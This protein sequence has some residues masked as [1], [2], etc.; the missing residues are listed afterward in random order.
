MAKG[1]ATQADEQVVLYGSSL[2]AAAFALARRLDPLGSGL[3]ISAIEQGLEDS[4][5]EIR[6][7]SP[8]SVLSSALN[9]EQNLFER[10]ARATW[11]W[12]EPGEGSVP[13][14]G[15]FGKALAGAAYPVA[16][17]LDP[18]QAGIHYEVIKVTLIGEGDE[19]R[20][21]NP[22]QTM[23]SALGQAGDR[24]ERLGRGMSRWL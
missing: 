8:R 14:T 2:A 17:R 24:F 10:S 20:G 21:P 9:G 4:G 15:L 11:R 19:V 23:L 3:H 6:G 7:D 22:G 13:V 18:S 5:V 16:R 12:I 1:S